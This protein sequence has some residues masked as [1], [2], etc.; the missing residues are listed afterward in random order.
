MLCLRAE[1]LEG[2]TSLT[3]VTQMT[4]ICRNLGVAYPVTMVMTIDS[5]RFCIFGP[6]GVIQIYYYYYYYYYHASTRKPPARLGKRSI[7]EQR[8][9]RQ[10]TSD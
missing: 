3:E 9:C 8:K 2:C 5:M 10:P 1:N 4:V 6:E 7:G